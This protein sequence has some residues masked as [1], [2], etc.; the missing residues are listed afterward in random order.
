[1]ANCLAGKARKLAYDPNYLSPFAVNA[2]KAGI[3]IRGGK[4]DDI[5]V[6][7]SLVSSRQDN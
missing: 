4:P 7:I 6:L 3:E 1:M 5:T 2:R